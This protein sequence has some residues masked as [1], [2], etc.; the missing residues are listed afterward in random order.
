MTRRLP[1]DTGFHQSSYPAA[2]PILF[3]TSEKHCAGDL[4]HG[5]EKGGVPI[6]VALNRRSLRYWAVRI[7]PAIVILDLGLD[8]AIEEGESLERDGYRVIGISDDETAHMRALRSNFSIVLPK[9]ISVEA[10]NLRLRALLRQRS[11]VNAPPPLALTSMGALSIDGHARTASWD[12]RKVS[13]SK[14]PF[15]L[16]K[17]LADRAGTAVDKQELLEEFRWLADSDLH[18]AICV[19]RKAL[20]PQ[21]AL[22]IVNR[23]GYGY[24]YFPVLSAIEFQD[25]ESSPVSLALSSTPA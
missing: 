3:S 1:S 10:L 25:R 21:G 20:G 16:L 7:S 22:H 19:I 17:Y 6:V 5:L 18:N 24:G 23:H 14:G 9:T 13:L 15:Q 4:I 2:P 8:W 11:E 12:H